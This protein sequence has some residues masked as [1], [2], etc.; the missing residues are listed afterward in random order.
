MSGRSNK[1]LHQRLRLTKKNLRLRAKVDRDNREK[2]GSPRKG[3][4]TPAYDIFVPSAGWSP[5]TFIR[6]KVEKSIGDAGK[7]ALNLHHPTLK[8]KADRHVYGQNF[9]TTQKDIKDELLRRHLAATKYSGKKWQMKSKETKETKE[10]KEKNRKILAAA[11]AA[12][13]FQDYSRSLSLPQQTLTTNQPTAPEDTVIDIKPAIDNQFE[14]EK[15]ERCDN[16]TV[17]GGRKTKRRRKKL[18]R[19][20]RRRKT[21]RRKTRRTKRRVKKHRKRKT[22]KRKK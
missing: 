3:Y 8:V 7:K 21:R 22:R 5:R 6:N 9:K 14:D 1:P 12:A 4:I 20:T 2:F 19:K 13:E 16:C 17:Q 18:H 11:T 15:S 10:T